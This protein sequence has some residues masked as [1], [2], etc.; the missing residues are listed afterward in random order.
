MVTSD[1]GMYRSCRHGGCVLF[2]YGAWLRNGR[3]CILSRVWWETAVCRSDR[4]LTIP[5]G[6][7]TAVFRVNAPPLGQGQVGF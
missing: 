4:R 3:F 7:Q 2:D 5:I 1:L 6:C